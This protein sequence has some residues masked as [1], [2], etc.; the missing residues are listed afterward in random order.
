[1]N[2]FSI[3]LE[4]ERLAVTDKMVYTTEC[5]ILMKSML[6]KILISD[7]PEYLHKFA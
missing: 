4:N 7:S 3:I 2:Q 6:K 1:M 5:I